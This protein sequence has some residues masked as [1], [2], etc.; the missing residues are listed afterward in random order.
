MIS[1]VFVALAAVCNSLMDTSAHH[2]DQSILTRFGNRQFWD[3]SISWKNKYVDWDNND[4]RRTRLFGIFIKPVSLTDSWHLFKRL[5]L[6][7]ISLA[8]VTYSGNNLYI[9]LKNC[10]L[11]LIVWNVTFHLFYHKILLKHVNRV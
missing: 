3:A 7:F 6:I 4:R 11:T 10:I 1:L 8:I 5:M 9:M 2:Y